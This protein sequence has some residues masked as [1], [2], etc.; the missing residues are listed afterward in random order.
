MMCSSRPVCAR[1]VR[2]RDRSARNDSTL[3]P[4]RLRAYS[5]M[6][7]TMSAVHRHQGSN[8]LAEGGRDEGPRLGHVDDAQRHVVLAAEHD[9]GRVHHPELALEHVVVVEPIEALGA[10][11]ETGIRGVDA[12]H[13]GAL[14]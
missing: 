5:M 1:P 10:G 8:F 12:I 9:G 2:R 13:L 4:M 3:L 14:D 11:V 6:S 7:L